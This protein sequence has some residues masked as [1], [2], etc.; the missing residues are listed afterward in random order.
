MDPVDMLSSESS[1]GSDV[2]D[3][4]IATELMEQATYKCKYC[5]KTYSEGQALGGHQN[6]HKREREITKRQER[7]MLVNMNPPDP[8]PYPH[9][10][11]SQY[12]LPS[13]FEQ[14]RYIIDEPDILHVVYNSSVGSSSQDQTQT[15]EPNDATR[16]MDAEKEDHDLSLYLSLKL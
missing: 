8:Y 4:G 13:G 16:E 15:K 3:D 9:P 6:V 12:A 1:Y 10:F 7:A 11:P 2:S 14:R 5:P